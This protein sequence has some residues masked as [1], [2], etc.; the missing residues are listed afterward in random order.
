[1]KTI[2]AIFIVPLITAVVFG[3]GATLNYL[4][5]GGKILCN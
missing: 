2:I 5:I 1:M 3:F 4:E